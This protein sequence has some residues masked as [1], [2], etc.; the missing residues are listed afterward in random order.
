[1]N[2]KRK[3]NNRARWP[4]TSAGNWALMMALG[5]VLIVLAIR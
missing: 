1:M 5:V 2:R 4:L 3:I